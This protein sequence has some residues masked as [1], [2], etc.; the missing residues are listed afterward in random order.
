MMRLG[1]FLSSAPAVVLFNSTVAI[2]QH[3]AIGFR[4][5]SVK[6]LPNGFE[7][8][9]YHPCAATR[10]ATRTELG[11]GPKELIVALVARYHPMKDHDAFI[12]AM[13]QVMRAVPE[14][15]AI[16]VGRGLDGSVASLT[17]LIEQLG[18]KERFHLAGEWSDLARLYPAVDVLCLTSAWGE[19]FPNVVGEAMSCGVPCVVT[20]VG[21]APRIVDGAG[22]VVPRRDPAAIADAVVRM[23]QLSDGERAN[24]G[25]QARERILA[26]YSIDTAV[27]DYLDVC[28]NLL[29][30]DQ[31]REA[32]S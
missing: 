2:A 5:R 32:R 4:C 20:D 3:E 21:D 11:I 7:T 29:G 31:L 30:T 17:A 12:R 28:A 14:A 1:A 25:T 10:T 9:V 26:E 15:R 23:L 19:G 8:T 6:V 18:V 16:M 13:A 27:D 22:F 24:L